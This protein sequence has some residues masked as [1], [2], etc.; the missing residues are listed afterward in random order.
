MS[1]LVLAPYPV[2]SALVF[3]PI[4]LGLALLVVPLPATVSKFI[5][6][7]AGLAEVALAAALLGL[8]DQN[9]VGFQAAESLPWLPSWGLSYSLGV[10]GISL[11][12]VL[13]T[14]LLLP[15]CV[16]CSW[17]SVNTRMR[18]FN[19]CLLLS[20]GASLGVFCSLDFVLFFIFWEA[21]IIP[22]YFI[23]AV[24]GGPDRR[25]ASI[26]FF[27]YTLA[28]GIT[29]LAAIIA[30]FVNS[31]TFFIPDLMVHEF[32]Q[33]FQLLTFAAM[34]LA[35]VIKV[36]LFPLHTWLPAAHVEA[37]AAGSVLLAAVLLKMGVY[38]FLRFCLPIT[39][40]AS[41]AFTPIMLALAIASILYGGLTALGQN[42]LKKLIAYSSVAHMGFC[43]LGIFS[44][45]D[46]GREGAVLIM[47]SHGLVTGALF[48]LVGFVYE[49]SHS[50][51]LGDLQALGR[52]LPAWAAFFVFF[53]LA[54]FGFPG[55][56]PFVGEFLALS[57]AFAH[58]WWTGALA[59][60]GAM[61]GAAYMLRPSI[62]LVWGQPV[63]SGPNKPRASWWDLLPREWAVLVP[64]VILTII[65][66]LAPRLV[67]NLTEPAL[68]QIHNRLN[69]ADIEYRYQPPQPI[70]VES[71][72]L[73]H[74]QFGPAGA[75]GRTPESS[76]DRTSKGGR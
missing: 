56:A 70:Q 19:G 25:Y 66:G 6:L 1:E 31:G 24:W 10:D 49:R 61:L 8:F 73:V 32:G 65:L 22:M 39:P 30:F 23:I 60:P 11:V 13:L 4:L 53:A 46:L 41:E 9:T 47:V 5:A 59:I 20:A 18:E 67:L 58:I 43:I 29:L 38:G 74:S 69:P 35:F 64:L 51:Q 50:R 71:F 21:M 57:G 54:S 68:V 34:A 26:K 76:S 2:L 27:I 42:D 52:P 15:L 75:A 36:P 28:G 7:A 3:M 72:T 55:L 48:F 44:G 63:T 33:T 12:M 40:Y 37:P 14:S 16:L 17:R 45:N 62:A